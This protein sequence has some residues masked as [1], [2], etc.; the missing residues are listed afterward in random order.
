MAGTF[1][2]SGYPRQRRQLARE[3]LLVAPLFGLAVLLAWSGSRADTVPPASDCPGTSAVDAQARQ[4]VAAT[5]AGPIGY[6]R[7]GHGEPLLLV[8]GYRATVSEWNRAFL[9]ALAAHR[10]VI[11]MDNPGVGLSRF[12][13]AP[14]TME[15]MA[16]VVSGFIEALHL[17]KV[18]VVGWSMGGMIAQQLALDHPYQVKSLVLMSTTPPGAAAAPVS[19]H[20][21]AVLSGQSVSP[22]E[23]IMGVLF[24][25]DAQA[26]AIRCFRAEMFAPPGYHRSSVDARVAHAQSLAMAEWWRDNAAYTSL[27]RM[28]VPALV[29]VGDQDEVLSPRNADALARQLPKAS[30]KVFADGGH[31]LMYQQPRGVAEAIVDFLD[32]QARR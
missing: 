21:H 25:P 2:G 19:A 1:L 28:A 23:A 12:D 24:P 6:Y 14:E 30:L 13:H 5:R 16:D 22:F 4:G 29:L 17:R 10:D 18:D 20:V 3:R 8:T 27:H 15:G 31:A 9:A 7:F 26:Q 32:A 11:V